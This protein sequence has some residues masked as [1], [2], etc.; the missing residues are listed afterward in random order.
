M[1]NYNINVTRKKKTGLEITKTTI[2][3]TKKNKQ[4]LTMQD[5]KAVVNR[6]NN[7]SNDKFHQKFVV[8]ARTPVMNFNLKG[9]KDKNIKH[10]TIEEYLDG[11]VKETTKLAKINEISITMVKERI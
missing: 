5:I 4:S 1:N 9:Y 8:V 3:I 7:N 2:N 11:R 10:N 6:L